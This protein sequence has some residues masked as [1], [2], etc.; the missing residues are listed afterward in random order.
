MEKIDWSA[1]VKQAA[2][3]LGTRENHRNQGKSRVDPDYFEAGFEKSGTPQ[4]NYDNGFS[5]SSRLDRLSRPKKQRSGIF[6]VKDEAK[7]PSP[8]GVAARESRV[9]NLHPIAVSLLVSVAKKMQ[10]DTEEVLSELVKLEAMEPAVQIKIWTGYAIKNGLDPL[11]IVY[12]FTR[13]S[14][15]GFSCMSCQHLDMKTAHQP[16]SRRLY[17]WSCKKH[18]IILEAYHG[19]ERVLIAPETCTDYQEPR[20]A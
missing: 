8:E 13:S 18:H 1:L 12:P 15:K 3:E 20:P 14:G 6:D 9:A 2:H 4:A 17:H 10:S 7:S 11:K 5:D 16:N 19:L